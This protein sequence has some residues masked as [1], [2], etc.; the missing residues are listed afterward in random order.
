MLETT[1]HCRR[2]S[3][4]FVFVGQ[5]QVLANEE[6]AESNNAW[7]KVNTEKRNKT[8]HREKETPKERVSQPRRQKL[9]PRRFNLFVF[10]SRLVPV[11]F[12][13]FS[14]RSAYLQD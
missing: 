10:A 8:A 6:I 14:F 5:N 12:F 11:S 13:S 7:T 3:F 1:S 2:S 4:A 9:R